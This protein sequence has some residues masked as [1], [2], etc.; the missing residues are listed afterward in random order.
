MGPRSALPTLAHDGR[1]SGDGRRPALLRNRERSSSPVEGRFGCR[2]QPELTVPTC[3]TGQV[4][5]GHAQGLSCV[6]SG[7]GSTAAHQ[8]I[9]SAQDALAMT[10]AAIAQLQ[11]QYAPP[12]VYL[13]VTTKGTAGR[14]THT[15]AD[16]GI[17]AARASC[18]DDY[19]DSHMCTVYELYNAAA[20]GKLSAAQRIRRAWIYFPSWNTPLPNPADPLWGLA[21]NCGGCTWPAGCRHAR[22]FRCQR[23]GPIRSSPHPDGPQDRH[24]GWGGFGAG[25]RGAGGGFVNLLRTGIRRP[26]GVRSGRGPAAILG[27]ARD[28]V[29]QAPAHHRR[30]L[31]RRGGV[32]A[33]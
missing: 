22:L 12:P 1:L 30:R 32:L 29:P 10:E 33:R 9:Q 4:L 19:P 6:P 11:L 21:D 8:A 26:A 25:D 20:R 2:G 31:R 16:P 3:P 13:G 7:L 14:I 18:Q 5:T 27:A 17:A 15:G 23:R 24:V 28:Q